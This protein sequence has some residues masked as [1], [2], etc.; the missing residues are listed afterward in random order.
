MTTR[1][2]RLAAPAVLTIALGLVGTVGAPMSTAATTP[3]PVQAQ[4]AE[5]VVNTYGVVAHLGYTGSPYRN[6]PL[7]IQRLQELNV[8]HIR[9]RM[10]DRRPDIYAAM[11]TINAAT[12]IKFNLVMGEPNTVQTPQV[13]L[14][15]VVHEGLAPIVE[16]F[17]GAN[18]W[19]LSGRPGWAGELRA[20]QKAVWTAVKGNPAT[21]SIP[22]LAPAL[23][24]RTGF[25]E[26]GD[27]SAWCDLGNLHNYPGAQR[28]SVR[29]DDLTPQEKAITGGK[30]VV[31]SESGYHN[32]HKTS[33][34][35][36]PTPEWLA[37]VY[38]PKLV[39][40]H[41]IRGTARVFQYELF[42]YFYEP[43]RTDQEG[44][45]GLNTFD[46]TPKPAFTATANLYRLL[47]DKGASFRPGTLA[48]RLDGQ[49]S[50]MR[51]LLLAKSDGTFVVVVW[52][53]VSAYDRK[54]RTTLS[55][56][57]VTPTLTLASA[58]TVRVHRPSVS[59]A[60]QSTTTAASVPLPVG[61][62]VVVATIDP[63]TAP[64]APTGVT[65]TAGET[66]AT[67][68]WTAPADGGA[69]TGYTVTAS[70]GQTAT[71]SGSA[72]SAT[73]TGLP[74][75]APVTFTVRAVNA[76]GTSP[77]SAPSAAVT[78]LPP[79]TAPTAPSL[80]SAKAGDGSAQVSWTAPA[81]NGGRTVVAYRITASPGGKVVHVGGAYRSGTVPGL[82]NG[83]A[84][85][86]SVAAY[87]TVGWSP[88]SGT[89]ASAVPARVAPA[90]PRARAA[91]VPATALGQPGPARVAVR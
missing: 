85:T 53:D 10:Y 35:H 90:R 54:T 62:D 89:T 59:G 16:S 73:V 49:S 38:A 34:G 43:T 37:G 56:P 88:E 47:A 55:V 40:E 17:E 80:V 39:L 41:Y 74:A 81:S 32:A 71:A 18:E 42:D 25:T 86:F 33:E 52:R 82:A 61:S 11:K 46:G 8:R 29:I 30:P 63:A 68:T 31:Y 1:F 12:G 5:S 13:L 21:R 77:A 44:H 70:T 22:V 6:L 23:G 9:T 83:V 27:I 28:P 2:S 91:T 60:A 65:A 66:S 79:A 50:D 26:L 36:F 69:V 72:R 4:A 76:V 19:N 87:N 3:A 67:V 78:P 14:D 7:V 57:T 45:F 75:G 64:G 51:Q 20:H 58:A 24:M 48:Y 84:Y 15:R